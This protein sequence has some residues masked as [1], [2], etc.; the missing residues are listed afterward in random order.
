M[1]PMPLRDRSTVPAGLVMRS[2]PNYRP[3]SRPT[4]GFAEF[5]RLRHFFDRGNG[6]EFVN[7]QLGELDPVKCKISIRRIDVEYPH[8]A[9]AAHDWIDGV[10]RSGRRLAEV[11]CDRFRLGQ[12]ERARG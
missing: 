5:L 1:L 10:V 4:E 11:F 6:I 3:Q 2:A 7:A 12:F 8:D 9:V